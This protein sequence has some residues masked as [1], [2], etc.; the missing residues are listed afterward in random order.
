MF[1]NPVFK[2]RYPDNKFIVTVTCYELLIGK[3]TSGPFVVEDMNEIWNYKRI[4]FYQKTDSKVVVILGLNV[5]V[6]IDNMFTRVLNVE[7]GK[8]TNFAKIESPN[9]LILIT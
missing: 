9:N 8:F 1:E 3:V 6:Y 5:V 2:I 4:E 7:K